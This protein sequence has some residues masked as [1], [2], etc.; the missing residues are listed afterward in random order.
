MQWVELIFST[1]HVG[2]IDGNKVLE[3]LPGYGC[4]ATSLEEWQ[5]RYTH[6]EKRR[7]IV[8]SK[9]SA[10]DYFWHHINKNTPYDS[11][12]DITWLGKLLGKKHDTNALDNVELIV[13][14]TG[15]MEYTG[16]SVNT[17]RQVT[18]SSNKILAKQPNLIV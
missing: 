8:L 6:W 12:R 17:L 11:I 10:F 2:V 18:I 5:A 13:N 3:S 9:R 15:W 7:I 14:G 1:C 16:Y 4:I